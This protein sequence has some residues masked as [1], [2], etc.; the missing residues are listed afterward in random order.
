M[1]QITLDNAKKYVSDGVD[2]IVEALKEFGVE[3][4]LLKVIE[5]PE[6]SGGVLSKYVAE[7]VFEVSTSD[8]EKSIRNQIFALWKKEFDFVDSDSNI[9]PKVRFV[10]KPGFVVEEKKDMKNMLHDF[11]SGR[12][13][14]RR[15]KASLNLEEVIDDLW[16]RFH[17]LEYGGIF[18]SVPVSCEL[19]GSDG[20]SVEVPMT[21]D[22]GFSL[23]TE[24]RIQ[25]YYRL[26]FK[27][28]DNVPEYIRMGNEPIEDIIDVGYANSSS[29]GLVAENIPHYLM[30]MLDKIA[31]DFVIVK[32]G[33]FNARR[34]FSRMGNPKGFDLTQYIL[35]EIEKTFGPAKVNDSSLM[36]D[37]K[38][39]VTVPK[40]VNY[41]EMK[42]T[43]SVDP[44]NP[45]I[46]IFKLDSKLYG[47]PTLLLTDEN[48]SDMFKK[49]FSILNGAPNHIKHIAPM[50]MKQFKNTMDK[51]VKERAQMEDNVHTLIRTDYD[52]YKNLKKQ[53][54]EL[55]TLEKK[56][57]KEDVIE[58]NSTK[59]S[60]FIDRIVKW[61]TGR[62]IA[63]LRRARRFHK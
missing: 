58:D 45:N 6:Y 23:D 63:R 34:R 44:E 20:V 61:F 56:E 42:I 7:P 16:K 8:D 13:A 57:L 2:N 21:L 37:G 43:V 9:N 31:S 62:R 10:L 30:E 48:I 29:E 38:T 4:K 51:A 25:F 46:I 12:R 22:M 26:F 14:F 39:V 3:F 59:P 27:D 17:N 28:T 47:N 33:S 40:S 32:K 36:W 35:P 60:N 18:E 54:D 15:R 11:E 1:T 52:R 55:S 41:P 49:S 5:T 53:F 19:L 24:S 50:V